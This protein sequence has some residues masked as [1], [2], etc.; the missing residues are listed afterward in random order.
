MVQKNMKEK[1]FFQCDELIQD[2]S[3]LFQIFLVDKYQ[4]NPNKNP[5]IGNSLKTKSTPYM[6]ARYPII[7]V[8]I[9]F[10][11]K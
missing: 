6:V 8:E 10:I 7:R 2:L 3:K 9:V 11:R 1:I 4:T 5:I